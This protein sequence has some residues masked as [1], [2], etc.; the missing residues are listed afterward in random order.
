MST[1]LRGSG[2]NVELALERLLNGGVEATNASD[3][4]INTKSHHAHVNASSAK[5]RRSNSTTPSKSSAIKR[6]KSSPVTSHSN[7]TSAAAP[8]KNQLLLCKRW[9]VSCS[10]T[11][12]GKISYGETCS[13]DENYKSAVNG[14]N[15]KVTPMVRFR[16]KN[17]EGTLNR[18][19]CEILGPLLRLPA[20]NIVTSGSNTA[21]TETPFIP[22][23]YLSAEALMEDNYLKIGSDIPINLKIFLNDPVAFFNLFQ[24]D[25]TSG[26]SESSQ[27]FGRKNNV[28]KKNGKKYEVTEAAFRL[29][30]WAERGE[31]I[32]YGIE[33]GGTGNSVQ[34]DMSQMKESA[35][36]NKK[37]DNDDA[38]STSSAT[39]DLVLENNADGDYEGEPESE[40]VS[41]LNQ[42]VVDPKKASKSIILELPDPT[43]FK[44]GVVLRPYQ[45]QA[46]YWMCRRE[47][48]T[49]EQLKVDGKDGISDG[50]I[51]LLAELASS[52]THS[53]S[54]LGDV[55]MLG[56]NGIAC[57]CGPV[58]VGDDALA[59]SA[60]PVVDYEKTTDL[61][62]KY[63]H[64]PLWK[65]RYLA[66]KNLT[67]VYAFYVNELLGIAS[68]SP[69]NP[70]K[71]CVGGILADQMGLGEMMYCVSQLMICLFHPLL[72]LLVC[73]N[74]VKL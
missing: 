45:R 29:L 74:Q 33:D 34:L 66:N 64:H 22:M 15:S 50:E 27:F 59:S 10:K 44:D 54:G 16:T 13:F 30:Q 68:A 73:D 6:T 69:P 3:A 57:D 43:G 20:T 37:A 55:Q 7:V 19:L 70:P 47:G 21:G 4:S 23:I 52:M 5:K 12:R 62:R 71:Q 72:I 38:S 28:S 60:V 51:D 32:D 24:H 53:S 63:V 11:I 67:T 25:S 35:E 17:A 58:V 61:G 36:E 26:K 65:R 41:E 14:N 18:Y 46:L 40:E 2:Y 49:L 42:L 48:L 56:G 9:T 31:E 8:S 39:K 1:A